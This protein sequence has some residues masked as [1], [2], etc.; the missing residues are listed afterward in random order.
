[1][2]FGLLTDYVTN[3][4]PAF[5]KCSTLN[6]FLGYWWPYDLPLNT[7]TWTRDNQAAVV[8]NDKKFD[9]FSLQNSVAVFM[10]E[11]YL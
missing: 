3:L 8:V 6:E 2:C 10:A 1:M 9:S 4:P 5:F 7:L 11:Q